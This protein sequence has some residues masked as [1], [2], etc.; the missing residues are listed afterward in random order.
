MPIT[1]YPYQFNAET[2]EIFPQEIASNTFVLYHGTAE[3]HSENIE[4]NGFHLGSCPFDIEAARELCTLLNNPLIVPYDLPNQY[5]Q[6]CHSNFKGYIFGIEN[7]QLRLSFSH[8][9]Y[10]CVPFASGPLKGGQSLN[11][12]NEARRIINA[13]IVDN[14]ILADNI[15]PAIINLFNEVEQIQN[16]NGVVY[17]IR[18]PDTLVG[19]E[20]G[21]G[22]VH[23]N[24]AIPLEYIIGKVIIPE[25]G[26]PEN[27]TMQNISKTHQRKL[28]TAPNGLGILIEKNN[29][30]ED[31]N[32]IDIE[33]I[34]NF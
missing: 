1:T 8:L 30:P 18:F 16:S 20:V 2:L 7:G 15:T 24:L 26:I 31:H 17:A 13:A 9:S 23:S 19:L 25:D 14:P 6:T 3:Y 12:V 27:I 21:I 33:F 34:D 5:E 28:F 22:V 32:D 4:N 10:G 29:F 11:H